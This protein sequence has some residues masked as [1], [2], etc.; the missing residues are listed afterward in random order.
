METNLI[1]VVE[2]G[3]SHAIETSTILDPSSKISPLDTAKSTQ[4]IETNSHHNYS[5]QKDEVK[6]LTVELNLRS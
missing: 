6:L 1:L 2:E 5:K 3:E 4:N